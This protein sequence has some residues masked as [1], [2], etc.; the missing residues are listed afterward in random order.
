MPYLF[1]FYLLNHP[2]VDIVKNPHSGIF[3]LINI[4]DTTLTLTLTLKLACHVKQES[5]AKTS[6]PIPSRRWPRTIDVHPVS[7]RV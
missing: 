4:Q 5:H 2:K 6:G 7:T 3:I 1:I